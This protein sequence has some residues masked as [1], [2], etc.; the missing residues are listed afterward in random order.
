MLLEN[1][2]YKCFSFFHIMAVKKKDFVEL[3]FTGKIKESNQIFD[4]TIKEDAEKVGLKKVKP[5]IVCIGE[6]MLVKGFDEAL[7]GKE[8]NKKYAIELDSKNA[9]GLRDPKLVKTIPLSIF[10]EK[11]VNPYPGLILNMDGIIARVSSVSGGRVIT[12]FNSPLAGKT[13]TYEFTIKKSIETKEE[14][15]K[16][17]SE[18]FLGEAETK[19][20]NNKAVISSDKRIEKNKIFEQ[21]VKELLDIDIEYQKNNK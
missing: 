17:L 19:I 20:E 21:K 7:G 3:D 8:L 16:A 10:I 2:I 13:I 12:D 14:K 18:F 4:T 9:F 6:G 5:L 15:L 1:N 11:K